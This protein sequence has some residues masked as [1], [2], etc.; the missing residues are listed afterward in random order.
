MAVDTTAKTQ[1]VTAYNRSR[2]NYEEWI[3]T[4]GVPIHRGYFIEDVR[5]VEVGWW[6]ERQ[7]N[8]AFLVLAGQ[9]GVSE[10]RVTEI[11]PGQTIPPSRFALDEV[12]YVAE[13]RGL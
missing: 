11:L 10:A 2:S 8:T 12:V 4:T 9:E 3:E 13:G 1:P 6:E 5:T 7:C